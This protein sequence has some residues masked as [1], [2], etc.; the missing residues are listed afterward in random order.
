MKVTKDFIKSISK[1]S[2]IK[3]TDQEL[4]KLAPE[5]QEIL[6]YANKLQTIDTSKVKLKP[7]KSVP[8]SDLRDDVVKESLNVEEALKNAPDSEN[9]FFKVIGSTFEDE[10]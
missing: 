9:N 8:F 7:F 2:K 4:E 5:M 1:I 6:D 3:L 10:E